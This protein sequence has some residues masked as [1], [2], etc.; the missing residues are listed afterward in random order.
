MIKSVDVRIILSGSRSGMEKHRLDY[1]DSGQG[2]MVGVVKA[3]IKIWFFKMQE[4]LLH[5]DLLAEGSWP[6][7]T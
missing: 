3:A 1:F 4:I 5:D 2:Q 7:N 6:P